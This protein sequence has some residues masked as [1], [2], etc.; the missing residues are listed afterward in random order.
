MSVE[1]IYIFQY[2]FAFSLLLYIILCFEC[3]NDFDCITTLIYLQPQGCGEKKLMNETVA[4]YI[5]L[6]VLVD[7]RVRFLSFD[8]DYQNSD[9][10]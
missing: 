5:F 8:K 6:N 9:F 10:F 2:F 3:A 1:N 4:I 7:F